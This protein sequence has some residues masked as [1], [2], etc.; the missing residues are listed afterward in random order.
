VTPSDWERLKP[1]FTEA[2]SLAPED[3]TAFLAKIRQENE[4]LGTKLAQLLADVA[5]DDPA[6]DQP[7]ISF[8]GPDQSSLGSTASWH[9]ETKTI[10]GRF[11]IV[12]TLGLGGMGEVFE[13]EDLQLGGRVALKTI[14]PEILKNPVV[15]ARFKREILLGKRIAHPNV[16]RIH[17]LGTDRD[18]DGSETLFFT[19]EFLEGETLAARLRRKG[20]MTHVEALPLVQNMTDG[21]SAAHAAGVVHR[22]FKSGNVML[23]PCGEGQTRAVITDFGLARAIHDASDGMALTKPGMIA[24]TVAYM[25][26][27]QIRGEEVGPPIDIYAL[28]VVAYQMVTGKLPFEGDSDMSVAIQH[29]QQEPPSP[30]KCAPELDERWESAI[31]KCLRKE[32][33]ERFQSAE[34]L[35]WALTSGESRSKADTRKSN[36]SSALVYWVIGAMTILALGGSIYLRQDQGLMARQQRVAVLEFENI[37]GDAVN[38]AFC[39]GLMETLSSKLTELEQFQGTLSVVPASDVRKDKVTSAHEAQR[40]FGATL[41][42]TGSVQRLPTGIRLTFNVVDAR[43]LKQLRS[44]TVFV[45][46]SDT[47]LMQQGVIQQITELLDIQLR[48]DAQHRLAQGNTTVPGAYDYYLQ[49]AGYLASGASYADQAIAEFKRALEKDPDYA[50]AHAGLGHAYWNKYVVTKE[51]E[52]VDEAWEACRRSIELNPQLAEGHITLAILDSGTGRWNEAVREAQEAIRIDGFNERAYLELARS[53]AATGQKDVAESTLKKAISLRPGYW[54]NHVLYGHFLYEQARYPEA[55]A[56]FQQV[57]DLVPDNPSGYTNKALILHEEGRNPDAERLLKKS[58]EVKPTKVAYT[59]LASI[60]FFER[61]YA[62]AVPIMEKVV[63]GSKEYMQWGNL[64]DAYRWTPG[65]SEKA[66]GAYETAL[67]LLETALSVNPKDATAISSLALYQA[68]LGRKKQALDAAAK[69]LALSPKDKTILFN[70][71]VVSEL[72]DERAQAIGLLRQAVAGGFPTSEIA[73]D[74]ELKNLRMDGAY[75]TVVTSA[76]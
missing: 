38:G 65:N 76:N 29:L 72:L 55:E 9:R 14:R 26:P 20:R 69:S 74:P 37:G 53:L 23:V 75:R 22:D 16:C 48:P 52:W 59:N 66:R 70:A 49:G 33:R 73:T 13:A 62:E 35:K 41:A 18:E 8:T 1:L 56:E 3:R 12:R 71:A 47:I 27:E 31:L 19:M 63:P 42:I 32:P 30:R 10:A 50:L 17:D 58:I 57:I 5:G 44:H 7:L 4:D 2:L 15:A 34:D 64:G 40:N 39:R 6:F 28:G 46:E 43:R 68:K 11:R 60:Y 21:L 67:K 36:K 24:G 25:A 61:R 45:T 51:K 54:Y